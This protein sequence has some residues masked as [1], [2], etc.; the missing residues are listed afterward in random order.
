MTAN[1]IQVRPDGSLDVSVGFKWNQ[2]QLVAYLEKIKTNPASFGVEDRY[3]NPP[4][5]P[6]ADN[7]GAAVDR[8]VKWAKDGITY[9]VLN[10]EVD[11]SLCFEDVEFPVNTIFDI[12]GWIMSITWRTAPAT[13][14]STSRNFFMPLL[15]LY[16]RW[17]RVISH[18]ERIIL[19]STIGAP[20]LNLDLKD[21]SKVESKS[22]A[23]FMNICRIRQEYLNEA[24]LHARNSKQNVTEAGTA[25]SGGYGVCAETFFFIYQSRKHINP[26]NVKGFAMVSDTK[27]GEGDSQY[28]E[29]KAAESL[30]A[31]CTLSCQHLV[32]QCDAAWDWKTSFGVGAL[33]SECGVPSTPADG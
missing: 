7:I 1:A 31:P 10:V 6:G 11:L 29:K 13:G 19:G 20:S 21:T 23:K 2:E 3:I 15:A 12:L 22:M 27:H 16:A 25:G 9:Q 24:G 17:C 4:P 26:A 28:T 30:R 14:S 33:K 5:Q 18:V 32:T 8:I